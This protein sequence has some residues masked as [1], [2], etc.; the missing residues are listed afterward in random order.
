MSED[1]GGAYF[2]AVTRTR[3]ILAG[4]CLGLLTLATLTGSAGRLV[5]QPVA[6]APATVSPDPSVASVL[7]VD[8]QEPSRPVFQQLV[9]GLRL[10]VDR[11]VSSRRAYYVEALDI[12]RLRSPE[13]AERSVRWL[14]EKYGK[15]ELDVIIAN[16]ASGIRSARALRQGLGRPHIPIIAVHGDAGRP[17]TLDSLPPVE[18]GVNVL[19]GE[20]DAIAARHMQ[21]VVPG[22]TQVLVVAGV[23]AEAAFVAN[24]LRSTL[25]ESVRVDVADQPTLASLRSQFAALDERA[26][27]F[28][29]SLTVDG[30]GKPWTAR[31]FLQQFSPFATRPVFAYLSSYLGAGIVGGPVLDGGDLGDVVGGIAARIINGTP[32]DSMSSVIVNPGRFVYDWTEV[33]RFGLNP[34]LFPAKATFLNKPVPVWKQ[35]PRTSMIVSGLLSLQLVSIVL[36]TT[37]RRQLRRAHAARGVMSQRMLRAQDEE[38][39]RIA[40]DLHDDLC[41]EMTALA[42]EVD[43]PDASAHAGGAIGDRVRALIDRTREIAL[44]L[45]TMQVSTMQLPDAL[46]AHAENLME[47]TGIAMRVTRHDW[48]ELLPADITMALFRGVQEALQ[49]V[50]RHAD[51]AECSVTLR[52]SRSAVRVEVQDDGI[53]FDTASTE[54]AGLGLVTMRERMESVGGR[55]TVQSKPFGGTTVT[56]TV[57]L[58]SQ[59]AVS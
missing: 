38:R 2:P 31:D 11:R 40:R 41:Q 15:Q 25:E 55:C 8:D 49:N 7:I 17:Q 50:L 6:G 46:T 29:Y 33:K 56:F 27:I 1:N 23:P 43:R 42:L 30:D 44:G 39:Q 45:H 26:A 37:S 51:A 3:R 53:G 13:L 22:L 36:L 16:G 19:I 58:A 48:P 9:S 10:A 47:R 5:A 12:G 18:H 59:L 21:G 34:S 57:P 32:V 20:L 4:R 54:S 35:Y 14:V 24:V 28:Y 52:G